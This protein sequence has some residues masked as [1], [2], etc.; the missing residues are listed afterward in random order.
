MEC[1]KCRA[2]NPDGKSYCGDCGSRLD[3]SAGLSGADLRQ[4]IHAVIKEELKDQK[5][6][7][8]EVSEAIATR[9]TGWAKLLGY[10]VGVPLTLLLVVFGFLGI[11]TY[12]DFRQLIG[13]AQS[14]IK[15]QID[16]AQARAQEIEG[17][18]NRL[19]SEYEGLEA[20]L[21]NYKA[22]DEKIQS[23]EASIKAVTSDVQD[24]KE[25]LHPGMDRWGVK[26]GT[27]PDA[28]RVGETEFAKEAHVELDAEGH[29][30]ATVE[31]LVSLS[32]PS[33][34]LPTAPT[35]PKYQD[36]RARPAEFVIWTVEATITAC[37]LEVD[38]DFHLVIQG[39]SGQT[40]VAEVPNPDPTFVP[41]SSRW[42]KEIDVV[43]Q[44]VIAKL[45]PGPGIKR[46]Q[47]RA[48]I[49][50]VGFFDTVH[51]QLGVAKTNGIELHPVIKI[52]Y[53]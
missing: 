35:N 32:R 30:H 1:A 13:S 25:T 51:G 5:V 37:K 10:C 8:Y 50:G 53:L 17:Q 27:D 52:E 2:G 19:K 24:I 43:R 47:V 9:L 15:P 48:R 36:G 22:I 44:Q 49:T 21:A 45:N 29:S 42:A 4:Q 33:D 28:K 12:S 23:V 11:K 40:M 39:D 3:P 31:T 7:E 26:T 41:P 18:S 6:V 34:M 46:V 20:K 16:Q 14:T 38:G